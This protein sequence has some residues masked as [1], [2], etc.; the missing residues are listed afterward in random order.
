MKNPNDTLGISS[1]Y[2]CKVLSFWNR[3]NFDKF[4]ETKYTFFP[5]FAMFLCCK[6]MVM[7]NAK[8]LVK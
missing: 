5:D 1:T 4:N 2:A 8:T 7:Y 6:Y 3:V